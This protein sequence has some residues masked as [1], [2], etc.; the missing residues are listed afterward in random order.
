MRNMMSI[1]LPHSTFRPLPS[2]YLR[3]MALTLQLQAFGI[4]KDILANR[5]MSYTLHHGT[6][7]GDLKASL[8]EAYPQFEGLQSLSFAVDETY[9]KDD[10]S[11][12]DGAEVVIIPPVS[13]G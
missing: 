2:F 11:L 9:Q 5:K 3:A 1:F 4:A 10:F 12:T 7:I 6:T 13:G 8:M